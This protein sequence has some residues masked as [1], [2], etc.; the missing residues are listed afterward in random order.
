MVSSAHNF[1]NLK[2]CDITLLFSVAFIGSSNVCLTATCRPR[3]VD[4]H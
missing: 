1:T 3:P 2:F 4:L